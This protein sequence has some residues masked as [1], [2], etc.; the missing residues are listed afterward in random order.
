MPLNPPAL[1]SGFVV[2]NLIS[3]GNLGMDVPKLSMG[4]AIGVCQFLT[5]EAKV[6]SIDVGTLGVGSTIFPMIV[7]QPLLQ[8][9]LLSSFAANNLLGVKAP[10]FIA[11]LTTGLITGWTSLALLQITH[12]TVGL[13]TGVVKIVASTAVPAMIQGF[14]A[15]GMTG[16]G[17]TQF[18]QA[19]G[20]ALDTTFASFT[21][22]GVPIVG[23]ASPIGGS[24]V[25]LGTVI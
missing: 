22:L 20:Q 6:T 25:G 2:P 1:A 16:A 4:I 17:P 7:P 5:A 3:T 10:L 18:A 11:G 24:G 21:Q 12:P 23:S 19:I 9:A 13:G 14:S 15:M 8:G